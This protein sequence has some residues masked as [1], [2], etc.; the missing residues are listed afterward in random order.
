MTNKKLYIFLLIFFIFSSAILAQKNIVI[1]HTND[2]HSRIE[3]I[4]STDNSAP[5]MGGVVRRATYIDLV[6]KDNKNVLL[7]DSGDLLQGTP[8]FNLFKGKIEIEAM[9][10]M[11][12]DAATIGNHEFDYGLDVLEK[13]VKKAKFPFI[14][15]NYDFSGTQLDG[16]IK[17]YTIIK[18]DGI[19]IGI[20]AVNIQPNG[21]IA[22]Q[23]YQ[24]V[25]YIPHTEIA[26]RIAQNLKEKK[27]CDVIICLSHLG[28]ERDIEFAQKSRNIDIILGGHSHTFM[29]EPKFVNNLD[30]KQVMIH[31]TNG[32]G[33]NVG[34]VD[35]RLEKVGK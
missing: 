29:K 17:S 5:N 2:T 33:I 7:F 31:Q 18:K 14:C 11:H 26:N 12:Y 13:V 21:L 16:L 32:R 9:N 1:L 3:P 6:R 8:Y 4:P 34:K 19:K 35:I 20:I 15:S 22:E 25:K 28:Y 23:L 24:G 27:K 30:G 10:M